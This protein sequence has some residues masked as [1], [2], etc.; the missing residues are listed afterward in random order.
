MNASAGSLQTV[1]DASIS[2]GVCIVRNNSS[3]DPSRAEYGSLADAFDY[4]NVWLFQ[5]VLPAVLLTLNYRAGKVRGH[6]CKERFSLRIKPSPTATKLPEI[7]LNARAMG[8]RSDMEVLSTLVHEMVHLWQ[9]AFGTPSRGGYHNREWAHKMEQ[10]GLMPSN[11]GVPG[12]KRTGQRVTH[13]IVPDA[14]FDK[15]CRELLDRGWKL[16]WHVLSQ[17]K[18]N[19]FTGAVRAGRVNDSKTKFTCPGCAQNA[20]AKPGASLICGCC[21]MPM[22]AETS[23]QSAKI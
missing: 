14:S 5:G 2:D 23:S 11:T 4:F 21:S 6:Y 12:G 15:V 1:M 9:D 8:G 19:H 20:W 7:S 10:I 13:Y 3:A 22:Q 18:Q 16:D 17:T